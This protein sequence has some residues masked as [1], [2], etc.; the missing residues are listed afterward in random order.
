[1]H[2]QLEQ[3]GNVALLT[4]S[5]PPVNALDLEFVRGLES[6]LAELVRSE[7]EGLVLSGAGRAFSAGVDVRAFAAYG[8]EGRSA[9]ILAITRTIGTLYAAPFPVVSAI[10][11]HAMGGG[12]VLALAGDVRLAVDDPGA[13]L[14]L[15]EAQAGIPFPA[16][17]LEVIR[18]E[19]SPELLRRLTLTSVSVSAAELHSL[20]VIDHLR[21]RDDL[22]ESAIA[23]VR[24]LAAQRGFRL[25]KEQIRRPVVQRIQTWANAGAD[26]LIAA[27]E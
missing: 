24:A 23:E 11:G 5:R 17:P 20:G 8:R 12:F 6:A 13:R 22:L 2:F 7:P 21:A 15:Q 14:G 19:L 16:G 3:S 27:L 10:G 18:A 26:P 4:L 1:M 9:M 25:V